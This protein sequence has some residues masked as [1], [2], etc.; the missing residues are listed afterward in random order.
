MTWILYRVYSSLE[1]RTF[2]LNAFNSRTFQKWLEFLQEPQ[3][4]EAAWRA[5]GWELEKFARDK[6][7][8]SP[9][10]EMINK[11][12]HL[13]YSASLLS[14]FGQ[15]KKICMIIKCNRRSFCPAFKTK[16]AMLLC[17]KITRWDVVRELKGKLDIFVHITQIPSEFTKGKVTLGQQ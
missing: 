6:D 10:S 5:L 9:Q 2:V 3:N 8:L 16:F 17:P 4:Q 13:L 11:S 7:Q 15:Q 1:K 14:E 12:Y